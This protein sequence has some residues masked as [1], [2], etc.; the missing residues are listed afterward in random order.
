L[1]PKVICP[2]SLELH[3]FVYTRERERERELT[4]YTSFPHSVSV[5]ETWNNVIADLKSE[6][7]AVTASFFQSKPQALGVT[8]LGNGKKDISSYRGLNCEAQDLNFWL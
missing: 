2:D 1:I 3:E 7:Q 5:F 4:L 6:L 8:I